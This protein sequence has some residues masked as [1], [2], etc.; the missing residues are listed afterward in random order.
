MK[1]S[2][3]KPLAV[4]LCAAVLAGGATSAVYALSSI[5]N[6]TEVRNTSHSAP[7]A[8]AEKTVITKDETVYVLAGADGSVRK[9]IVS[10]WIKN[11]LG[12]SSIRDDSS[13]TGI[14]NIK[15]DETYTVNGDGMRVWDAQ[16]NDIYYQ[17]SIE[18]E[19]PVSLN[20]SYRLDGQSISPAELAGKSGRVTIRFDYK[21]NQ[22]ETVEIDG[23]QEKIYVPF[24]MLTGVLLDNDIFSDV[25]VSGGKLINDGSRTVVAGIAFPGLQ[26]NLNMDAQKLEI[27]DFVEISADVKNFEMMNTVTIAVNE[28]FNRLDVT[29]FDSAGEL[30]DSLVELTDAVNQLIDGSSQLYGGLCTLLEKSEELIAGIDKLAEGAGAL[31]QGAGELAGGLG[32]LDANSDA[33]NK[34]ALQVY[35]SLL[36]TVNKQIEENGITIQ[37]LTVKNYKTALAGLLQNPSAVQKQQM[38]ALANVQLETQLAAAGVPQAQYEAVKYMLYQR[39]TAGKAVEAAMKEIGALLADASVYAGAPTALPAY[40]ALYQA[41]CAQYPDNNAVAERITSVAVYLA[42]AKGGEAQQYLSTAGEIAQHAKEVSDAMSAAESDQGRA[43]IN[44][45][46]FSLAKQTLEPQIK[47]AVEQLDSYNRFYTGLSEYTAGVSSAKG[48]ADQLYAGASELYNGIL[49]LKNGAPALVGGVTELRDGAAQLSDGLKEF[50]EKGVKKLV[51]AVDG[52]LAGLLTRIRAT[53]DVSKNYKNFSGMPGDM[54]GQVKFIY[55]TDSVKAGK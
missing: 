40:D 45:L 44:G 51:D 48:G 17:G 22:Y 20:V 12:S 29:E 7:A 18:K 2:F 37:K 50:N 36:S 47:S 27:P 15:G 46:C 55:R 30:T 10:D 6:E 32:K 14:E 21:N 53:V 54:D 49:T 33:L 39:M 52:D 31:K 19:L 3:I 5:K 1:K 8:D 23:K 28:I 34:G 24:V 26:S 16:G 38:T 35:E 42:D 41:V 13:L 11:T 9:I 25:T 43:V 4:V